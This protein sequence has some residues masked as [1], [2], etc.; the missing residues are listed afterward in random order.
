[1]NRAQK[2]IQSIRAIYDLLIYRVDEFYLNF[3][4]ISETFLLKE[5]RRLVHMLS[6]KIDDHWEINNWPYGKKNGN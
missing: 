4:E 1:M 2:D 6:K 3:P 5:H